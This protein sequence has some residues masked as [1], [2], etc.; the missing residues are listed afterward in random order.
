MIIQLILDSEAQ[1][2]L[3]DLGIDWDDGPDGTIVTRHHL[4]ENEEVLVESLSPA[5]LAEFFGVD[6]EFL[7]ALNVV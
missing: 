4:E 6:S 7:I 5:E 3:L 1:E 2:N